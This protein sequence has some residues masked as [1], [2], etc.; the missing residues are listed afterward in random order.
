M[1]TCTRPSRGPLSNREVE[2]G[3][4]LQS[5]NLWL[6]EV[7]MVIILLIALMCAV[8]DDTPRSK[9]ARLIDKYSLVGTGDELERKWTRGHDRMSLRE[10]ADEFNKQLLQSAVEGDEMEPLDGEIDNF[11]RLLTDDDVTSGV[12]QQARSQLERRGVDI[13]QL[14]QDFVSYQSIRT[15]LKKYRDASAPKPDK[16]PEEQ[17]Q[18]KRDT[19]QR[20]VS[21]VKNVTEQSLTELANA[22][23]LTIGEFNVVVTV[24]VHCTDCS[25]QRSVSDLI[26]DGHCDC[27]VDE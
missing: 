15:Y 13:D 3:L 19:I 23:H 5:V 27:S 11:Y 6:R 21:R 14:E 16:S 4:A 20:L 2:W 7:V 12:R 1:F 26:R 8:T 17:R 25:S 24:R 22:G 9:V 18:K 10:L